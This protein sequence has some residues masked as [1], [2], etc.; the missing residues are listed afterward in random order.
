MDQLNGI[1]VK[2]PWEGRKKVHINGPGHMNKM[3]VMVKTFKNSPE[4]E[5]L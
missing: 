5:V 4:P 2:P 1:F 3:A